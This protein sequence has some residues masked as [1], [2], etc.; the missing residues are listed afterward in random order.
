MSPCM[1][2]RKTSIVAFELP[3]GAFVLILQSARLPPK[4]PSVNRQPSHAMVAPPGRP[5]PFTLSFSDMT[6]EM[7][8]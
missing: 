4:T 1:A 3:V 2:K 8:E 6:I 7:C 5:C